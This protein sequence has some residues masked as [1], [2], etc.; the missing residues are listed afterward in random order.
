MA[1]ETKKTA[2]A[3]NKGRKP[4]AETAEKA[5]VKETEKVL[6][7]TYS[8]EELDKT[9]AAAVEAALAKYQQNSAPVIQVAKDDYVTVLFIGAMARGT[10]VALGRLGQINRAGGT[11]DIPKKDFLQGLGIPVVDALLAKR[12]LIV[13]D[14]LTEEERDRFNLKYTEGELLSQKAFHKLFDYS[15]EEIGKIFEKLCPEHKRI[16]AKMYLTEYFENKSNK[17]TP[18]IVKELNRLSKTVEKQGL[19]TPILI[20][21]GNKF[22]DD[23]ED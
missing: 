21:M 20:D 6:E 1:E 14:G 7:K 12:Q 18:D 23:E 15:K 16:V 11:L 4:K 5:E 17:V 10:S 13:V 2:N 19:F 8:Q 3:S 22:V 9:V